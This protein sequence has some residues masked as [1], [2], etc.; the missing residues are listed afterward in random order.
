MVAGHAALAF[1]RL[2]AMAYRAAFCL[3]FHIVTS[4]EMNHVQSAFGKVQLQ[5][6]GL[7]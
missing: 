6:H 7:F 1:N 3:T 2:N 4:I 5:G